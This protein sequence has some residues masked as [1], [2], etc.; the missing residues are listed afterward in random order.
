MR[1]SIAICLLLGL[2][3]LGLAIRF[4]DPVSETM[5][6]RTRRYVYAREVLTK[7]RDKEFPRSD[8]VFTC[9]IRNA[10]FENG[11][12]FKCTV[13]LSANRRVWVD[14]Y[15][16][17]QRFL[18]DS[19]NKIYGMFH[20]LGMLSQPGFDEP[21]VLG[22]DCAPLEVELRSHLDPEDD[23]PA[24]LVELSSNLVR[25]VRGLPDGSYRVFTKVRVSYSTAAPTSDAPPPP[26]SDAEWFCECG[27]LMNVTH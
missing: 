8:A 19:D 10:V 27:E 14:S 9:T 15:E 23:I 18:F 7:Y 17:G 5:T 16:L 12:L 3:L 11:A 13:S 6:V 26:A 25:A 20:D 21:A 24:N 22:P 4:W 2:I 1:R